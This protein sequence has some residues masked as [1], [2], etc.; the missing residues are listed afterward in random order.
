MRRASLIIDGV[1]AIFLAT[2]LSPAGASTFTS[3]MVSADIQITTHYAYP[4]QGASGGYS[5][6]GNSES[7]ASF[8]VANTFR[9]LYIDHGIETDMELGQYNVQ[10]G[11]DASANYGHAEIDVQNHSDGGTWLGPCC[12]NMDNRA[13]AESS[14][15]D[16][17]VVASPKA[18]WVELGFDVTV[19]RE[20]NSADYPEVQIMGDYFPESGHYSY[21]SP[22]LGPDRE[23]SIS[24]DLFREIYCAGTPIMGGCYDS[25]YYS[26]SFTSARVFADNLPDP[27][28]YGWG[29]V[30]AGDP[31]QVA[32]QR[33]FSQ[34]VY[35]LTNIEQVPE[36]STFWLIASAGVL[37]FARRLCRGAH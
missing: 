2:S 36:P 16:T 10:L 21:Y 22:V 31:Y 29:G 34:N 30:I 24:V 5:D 33:L 3:A 23:V 19:M 20:F 8:S 12:I 27:Q 1:A 26:V 17:L 35:S 15:S 18:Q 6:F 25:A 7:H 13:R 28:I 11:A 14:F 9:G 37:A 32:D 4:G